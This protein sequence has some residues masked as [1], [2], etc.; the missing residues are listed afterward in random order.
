ME[1]I[2][3]SID[4]QVCYIDGQAWITQIHPIRNLNYGYPLI[5]TILGKEEDVIKEHPIGRV[6]E[7]VE[8]PRR[9][10]RIRF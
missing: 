6:K 8:T 9:R 10:T 5:P 4:E 1:A 3:W 7:V 2:K